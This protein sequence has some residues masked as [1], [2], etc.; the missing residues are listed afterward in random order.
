MTGPAGKDKRK[1]PRARLHTVYLCGPITGVSLNDALNWRRTVITSLARE[2]Q[3]I[4]PTRDF[5][6]PIRKSESA[7]TRSLTA[8]RLLHGKRTVARDRYDVQSSDLVLA[9]FL[10]ATAVSIGAVGEIF[11]ADAM[12]KPV[13]IVREDDNIHNHDMLNEIAGWIFADLDAAIGQIRKMTAAGS[14]N[15]GITAGQ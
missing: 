7:D 14:Y 15:A 13:I 12:G 5:V 11:W 6:D 9:C 10:G 3:F 1:A 2:A 8:E 4:D